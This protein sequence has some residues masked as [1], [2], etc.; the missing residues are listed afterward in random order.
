MLKN[1]LFVGIGGASGSVMR[2]LISFFVNK[3]NSSSFP[4]AT[5]TVNIIGCF[6]AGLLLASAAKSTALTNELKMLMI[7][8]FCGGLTTFSTFS[9][10]NV[11]LFQNGDYTILAIYVLASVLLGVAAVFAGL[12]II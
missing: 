12:L 2:Y 10:E 3:Y 1:I 5:F 11:T 4:F 7:V 9:A 8:G 6:V